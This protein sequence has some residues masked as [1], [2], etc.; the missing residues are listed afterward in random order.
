MV[1]GSV[2]RQSTR[3]P[4]GPGARQWTTAPGTARHARSDGHAR[5]SPRSRRRSRHRVISSDATPSDGSAVGGVFVRSWRT[6]PNSRFS[7]STSRR[8]RAASSGKDGSATTGGAATSDSSTDRCTRG[9]RASAAPRLITA[10]ASTF[11]LSSPSML[12]GRP[13]S[14]F[15]SL[16]AFVISASSTKA[17]VWSASS[18]RASVWSMSVQPPAVG[19]AA[20]PVVGR[21][22]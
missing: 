5:S 3:R 16:V 4:P 8:S 22:M 6:R 11:S 18:T 17:S 14:C 12:S 20:S 1:G 7:S 10:S 15:S 9:S 2:A 21:R 19:G 13:I